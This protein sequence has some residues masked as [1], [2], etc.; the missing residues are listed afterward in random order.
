MNFYTNISQWGNSL[1]VREV[2]DG[3]RLNTR[4]KYKPT[5]Y[6][7]SDEPTPFK[8]L[9]GG[10]VTPKTFNS[11][12]EGKSFIE[13][14]PD[15]P[16][17][18]CGQTMFAYSYIAD[19]FPN[20]VKWD[21]EHIKIFTIDIETECE[22]G[23]PDPHKAVDPLISITL[24]DHHTKEIMVWGVGK[25]NNTR[26]D[27][28]YV[29]CDTEGKLI[30]DF[31]LFWEGN[32]PDIITGWN[33]EF[34]DI[35][36]ICNRI[37]N[38]FGEKDVKRLSPWKSVFGKKV[39]SMGRDHQIYE[40]QG[41]AALD[42]LDLYRKFTYTNQESY[43]LDHIAYVELGERKDGNP[44]DTFKDWYKN[45]FQSFIEYN[46]TDVELVDRLEDKMKLIELCLTMAYD[47]KVNYTDVL[48]SVKYWDILI[49]NHLRKKNIVIPQKKVNKKAE[50]YEGAYVKDPQVGMHKW[51]MSFDLNSLYPHLIMQ[52]NI[53]PETLYSKG[54]VP[55]MSV[56]KLLDRKVDTSILKGV[57]LTPN[58]ALFKTDTKGFL[59][60]IMESM[61]NDRVTFKRKMLEAK[62]Q[63]ENTKDP[64]LLKDISRYNNIQMAKKISLN[65]AY[66]AIGNVYFRYY[67]LLLAEAIT[68]SGQLSIRWIERALNKYLNNLLGTDKHDYV[69][70]SDTDSVYITFDKLV[71]KVFGEQ[72]D[73]TKVINFLDTIATDKIEPFIDKS[74]QELAGYVNAHSNKMSMKREVIADK[75][76]W[77]AKKRYIL[78]AYDV[79]GVR[80]KEPQL[81]IMGIEAVK[82]S[83]PAPCRQKIKDALKI[84]MSGDEKMLNTFIQEF[85]EEFMQLPLEDIAYPRSVNGIGKFTSSNGLFAKGAPIHCKGAIL[86]N[87][88]IN[89]NNLS[90]KYELIQ[91][92]DKIKFLHLKEPNLYI[93]TAISFMTKLPKELDFESIID[94]DLQFTKSFTDPLKFITTK[95]LWKIDDSYGTQGTL[96]DFFS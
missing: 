23:F 44:F 19:E 15:Q 12:K 24:K 17:M 6:A 3:V 22:N 36:Y 94:K 84:I 4:V 79:E 59:P 32:C 82:S 55:K 64:K 28:T 42:Y 81:K 87:H 47:A 30:Q 61:Y 31:L 77:T 72:P 10:Y 86:Y 83:T 54:K 93:S 27:V 20:F 45:D 2:V 50:K 85:R 88:L 41:V 35:P 52:Y 95:I 57:T 96:E 78:N 89:K 74:Y 13:M 70:A 26:D 63:Y 71:N 1:L 9:K 76:I 62:Q 90:H 92:G 5:L 39:F 53:S 25:F 91:E 34:F 65:S 21:T 49:Y 18:A 43:R 40:I 56:D 58:G 7:H 14:Y 51:V 16:D 37:N 60:E 73:T 75:G 67:E 33:T 48:G 11:I 80:Y 38:L 66:G 8:T 69:L 29:E 68:T 46:I